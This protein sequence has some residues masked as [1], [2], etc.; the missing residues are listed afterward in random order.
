MSFAN[1]LSIDDELTAEINKEARIV[2]LK[3]LRNVVLATPVDTGRARGNWRVGVNFDPTGEIERKSRKGSIAIKVGQS[4]IA[5]AKDKG[6]V[7]IVIANN[8]SYIERLND[9]WSE[10]APAKF[11]EKAIRRAVK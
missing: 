5:G 3:A 11:V 8:L 2:A 1:D 9:G 4:E 7:D 6:L 10:Q